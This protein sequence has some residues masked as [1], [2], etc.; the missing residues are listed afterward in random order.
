[1]EC[2]L[3]LG[4]LPT[5]VVVAEIATDLFV[6]AACTETADAA[7]TWGFCFDPVQ[8]IIIPTFVVGGYDCLLE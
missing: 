5:L 1:M 6:S 3:A 7:T 8:P 2:V 4:G